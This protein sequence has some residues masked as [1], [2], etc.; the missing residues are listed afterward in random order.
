MKTRIRQSWRPVAA[1]LA[2]TA[3]IAATLLGVSA[4][5]AAQLAFST[6]WGGSGDESAVA[7]SGSTRVA[8]DAEG[9]FYV[10]GTTSSTDFPVTPDVVQGPHGGLDIFVTKLSATG[11]LIY[12]T[13]LGGPCDDAVADIAV[14]GAGN[15]YLTGRV[16]GGG[17]CYADVT[18]GVLVAKLDPAGAVVYA[19]ALGGSLADSSVG[20]AIAIDA[21][22][23]AYVTG[24]A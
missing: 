24:I 23:N 9:N 17:N 3:G 22:G 21:Q 7:F 16:N 18:A 8:V 2:V 1:L 5:G 4:A 19:R 11:N 14:D 13:V 6:Y 15:T 10:A 20:Q 12:S